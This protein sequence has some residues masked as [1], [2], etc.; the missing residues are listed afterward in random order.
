[1]AREQRFEDAARLRDRIVALERV[2]DRLAELRRLRALRVCLLAPAREP[3]FLLAVAVA[4]GRVAAARPVPLGGGRLE[5]D[6][7][8]ADSARGSRSTDPQEIG[9][10]AVVAAFMRGP[11]PE[12][13]VVPLEAEAIIAA[14][15]H[16]V[17]FAA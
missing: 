11:P 3:G 6:A 4:G 2:V 5:V 13:R 10:L 9:E 12:L 15:G 1:M 16:R 14:I 8:V 17:A 7:V